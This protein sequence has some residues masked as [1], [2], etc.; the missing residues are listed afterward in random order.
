MLIYLFLFNVFLLVSWFRSGLIFGG[1]DTGLPLYNPNLVTQIT[2]YMW[3][4]QQGT[5][6]SYPGLISSFPMYSFLS[7]FQKI[8]F[9][10]FALQVIFFGGVLVFASFGMYLTMK[11]LVKNRWISFLITLFYIVNPYSMINVWHRGSY[12]GMVMLAILPWTLYLFYRGLTERKIKFSLILLVLTP[13]FGYVFNTPAF[14]ATWFFFIFAFWC[15]LLLLYAIPKKQKTFYVGYLL[16]FAVLF[17]GI[18]L[19]WL[20]PFFHVAPSNLFGTSTLGGNIGSLRGVSQ[21]FTLPY[22]FRGIGTFYPISQQDWG[23]IYINPFFDALSFIE[24]GFVIV[25]FF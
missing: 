17:I 21:Y 20:I 16:T 3:W 8:G 1:G 25:S 24:F 9:N 6:Y 19:W 11:L 18:N 5:G 4:G 14:I 23:P 10:P 15:F 2:Q 13:F 12:N 7:L 22:A